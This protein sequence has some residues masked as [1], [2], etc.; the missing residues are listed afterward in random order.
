MTV[1]LYV[2]NQG[3]PTNG[4]TTPN[5]GAAIYTSPQLSF[6]AGA[7]NA[8]DVSGSNIVL[9]GACLVGCK[10]VSTGQIGN[11]PFTTYQPNNTSDVGGCQNGKNWIW[12]KNLISGTFS[13]LNSCGAGVSGDWVIHANATISQNLGQFTN[14]GANLAG[15]FAP[16]MTGSGSLA[17]GGAF[18]IDIT[19]LPTSQVGYLFVGFNPL[20]AD[21]KGGSFGPTPDLLLTLPTS[22][23]SLNL[24][25][26]MP[27]GAPGNFSFYMQ[28][29]TPDAG[30]PQGADATN[31]LQATTPP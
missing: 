25:A 13:W 11:P 24:P 30:A 5:P 23:G 16:Q 9:N 21:F 7:F 20:F 2:W 12:A 8:W 14:L 3:A 17:D 26:G 18:S 27:V 22:A 4:A 6:S 10:V 28:M 1:Q 31:T 29:W 19:G 15:N